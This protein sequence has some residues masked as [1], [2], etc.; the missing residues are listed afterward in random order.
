MVGVVVGGLV[1][2]V[3]VVEVDVEIGD[4]VGVRFV[5]CY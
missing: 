3:G 4:A 1:V 2:G 5:E